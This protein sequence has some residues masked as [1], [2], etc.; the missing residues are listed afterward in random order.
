MVSLEIL[1]GS[2]SGGDDGNV[3]GKGFGN[4]DVKVF[5]KGG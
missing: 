3:I 2:F 5:I 1:L 4:Y